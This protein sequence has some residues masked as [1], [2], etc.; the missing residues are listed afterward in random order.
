MMRFYILVFLLGTFGFAATAQQL[1]KAGQDDLELKELE[2]NFGKI[3]QGKPVT[4]N[5]EVSNR[6][7]KPLMIENVEA[8]PIVA[9]HTSL[10]LLER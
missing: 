1:S 8:S 2:F 9:K 3:R 10:P 5:F 7:K 6:G 4:H